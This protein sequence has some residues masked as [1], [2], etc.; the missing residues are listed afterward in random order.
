MA[1]NLFEEDKQCNAMSKEVISRLPAIA[2]ILWSF[3]KQGKRAEAAAAA[4]AAAVQF[5]GW[6]DVA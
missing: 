6:M 4:A 5:T 2:C 3:Q 1:G